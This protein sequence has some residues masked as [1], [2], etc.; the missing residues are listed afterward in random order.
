MQHLCVYLLPV[1]VCGLSVTLASMDLYHLMIPSLFTGSVLPLVT[2]FILDW[3]SL[4]L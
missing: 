2:G 4:Q 3:T 1:C